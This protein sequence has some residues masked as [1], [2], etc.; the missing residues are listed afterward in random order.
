MVLIIWGTT[1]FLPELEKI[2]D[3]RFLLELS[4]RTAAARMFSLDERQ[5]FDKSFV[6]TYQ[7]MMSSFTEVPMYINGKDVK[8]KSKKKHQTST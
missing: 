6:E 8:S 1:I 5:N 3:L 7:K 4:D 2:I